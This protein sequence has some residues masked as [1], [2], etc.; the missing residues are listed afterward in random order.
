MGKKVHLNAAWWHFYHIDGKDH[1]VEISTASNQYYYLLDRDTVMEPWCKQNLNGR[2]AYKMR[3]W[4][5]EFDTD[6]I[7]F[8]LKWA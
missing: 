5:F 1:F 2:F 4:W 8:K 3:K 7:A 6:A